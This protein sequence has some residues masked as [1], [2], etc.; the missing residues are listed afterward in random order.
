[1]YEIMKMMTSSYW[2]EAVLKRAEICFLSDDA[3]DPSQNDNSDVSTA[4]VVFYGLN[5][6]VPLMTAELLKVE[7]KFSF[8]SIT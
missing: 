8:A 1:M 2:C 4:D 7:P 5:I 3:D 6:I